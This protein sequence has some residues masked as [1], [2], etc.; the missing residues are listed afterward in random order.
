[1]C[2]PDQEAIVDVQ[3]I[4]HA[5]R[6]LESVLVSGYEADQRNKISKLKGYLI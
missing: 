6:G 3:C 1:M 5:S 2:L 4:S